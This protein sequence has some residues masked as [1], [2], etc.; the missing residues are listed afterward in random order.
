ME[1]RAKEFSPCDGCPTPKK[2]MKKQACLKT[3]EKTAEDDPCWDGYKQVGMKE[4]DGKKVPNCVPEGEAGS[5]GSKKSDSEKE[6]EK[7]A[8]WRRR[9]MEKTANPKAKIVGALG[10]G[11]L[12]AGAGYNFDHKNKTRN[13]LMGAFGG[14]TAGAGAGAGGAALTKA[15]ADDTAGAASQAAGEAAESGGSWVPS[16]EGIQNALNQTANTATAAGRA[17]KASQGAA[18]DIGGAVNSF[19]RGLDN[20][21][22]RGRKN[23]DDLPGAEKNIPGG[24]RFGSGKEKLDAINETRRSSRGGGSLTDSLKETLGLS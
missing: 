4:K 22:G 6:A 16:F 1:K 17:A 11:A 9:L 20:T 19:R 10:G 12:G 24:E 18:E 15:L 5:S 7:R 13:A 23:V 8:A 21:L 2:C 3:S 14:A